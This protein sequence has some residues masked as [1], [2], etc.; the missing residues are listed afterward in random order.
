[1]KIKIKIYLK[2]MIWEYVL[3]LILCMI[4]QKKCVTCY[5]L[6]NEF[7][8]LSLLFEILGNVCMAIVCFPGC[9]V[10]NFEIKFLIK[11]FSYITEN[12]RQKL[13]YL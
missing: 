4:F 1:M 5:V 9:N 12:L 8:C 11:P 10:I 6:S 2:K 7:H 13:K 3:Q